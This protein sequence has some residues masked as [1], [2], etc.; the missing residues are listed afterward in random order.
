M[1]RVFVTGSADGLGYAAAKALLAQGHRVVVHVRSEARR[2]A[3][4]GLEADV[5]VGDLSDES[6][7]RAVARQVNALGVM[8]AVIHNA[9]VY[10]DDAVMQV[11]VIAP[12]LLTA[13][14]QRPK[15]LVYLSSGLHQ[16]GR[17]SFPGRSYSDSKLFISTFA[18]A[19]A[20]RWPDVISS[21]VN[22]GWVPTKMGGKSAPDA[23]ELGHVTQVWLAVSDDAE[24]R[25][26]GHYWFHQRRA[27]AH[28]AVTDTAFQQQLLTELERLTGTP[29]PP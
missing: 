24:A 9:G 3:V 15:R 1:K 5:V 16:S 4:A 12:Y 7:T 10:Q 13:L 21:S 27:Q 8:D 2:E 28:V 14:L 11:N 29:L 6:Q 20:R 23:L 22:P 18:A 25:R 19:L 26:S 17:P